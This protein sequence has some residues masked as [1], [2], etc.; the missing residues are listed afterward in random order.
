MSPPHRYTPLAA[1]PCP[2]AVASGGQDW[3]LT[4]WKNT[5]SRRLMMEASWCTWQIKRTGSED[6][7]GGAGATSS[8]SSPVLSSPVLSEGVGGV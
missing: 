8:L 2:V 5:V 1:R 3:W 4:L 6:A 7:D